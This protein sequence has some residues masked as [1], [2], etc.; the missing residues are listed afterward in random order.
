MKSRYDTAKDIL[1]PFGIKATSIDAKD[2]TF[3]I[4]KDDLSEL[5][6]LD[7][8]KHNYQEIITAIVG[9]VKSRE[10]FVI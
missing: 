8:P 10:K 4:F 2:S 6:E 1:T 7:L 9:E 3:E 5:N